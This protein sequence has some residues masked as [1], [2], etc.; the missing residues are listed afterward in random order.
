[1]AL[2]E[3]RLIDEQIGE[4]DKEIAS[5]LSEHQD[6][7]Q[8]RWPFMPARFR[9]GPPIASSARSAPLPLP[10]SVL[11]VSSVV[12]YASRGYSA[13]TFSNSSKCAV[14]CSVSPISV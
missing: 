6:A 2:E 7:V 12:N 3:L 4:L 11:S 13:V 10:F 8:Q 14:P 5:L 1:M 9:A